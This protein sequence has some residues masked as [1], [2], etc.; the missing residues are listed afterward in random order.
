MFYI[1]SIT[2]SN[3][4]HI[5]HSNFLRLFTIGPTTNDLSSGA[6]SPGLQ[7]VVKI[8]RLVECYGSAVSVPKPE[9]FWN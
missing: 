5:I 1:Q 6:Y 8:L 2:N 7:V 9:N 3:I 4:I